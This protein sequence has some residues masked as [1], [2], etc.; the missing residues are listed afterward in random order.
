MRQAKDQVTG[1]SEGTAEKEEGLG[2]GT[3]VIMESRTFEISPCDALFYFS[4]RPL[5]LQYFSIK[6]ASSRAI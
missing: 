6:F 4:W 5:L 3:T 2:L 1:E